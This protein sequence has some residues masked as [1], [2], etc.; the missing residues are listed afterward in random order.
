[1]L[2]P[3][4]NGRILDTGIS[5]KAIGKDTGQSVAEVAATKFKLACFWIKHQHRTSREIGGT[6]KLPD[7]QQLLLALAC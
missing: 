1:M 6:S 4:D 3:V 2:L 7:L 5:N